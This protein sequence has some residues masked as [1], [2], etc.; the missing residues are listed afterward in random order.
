MIIYCPDCGSK[1][2]CIYTGE[3]TSN[4]SES[5]YHCENDDC[6]NDF[7]IVRDVNDRFVKMT[8]HFWG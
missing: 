2:K 3:S 7:N 8:R 5:I 6:A 1:L 4:F